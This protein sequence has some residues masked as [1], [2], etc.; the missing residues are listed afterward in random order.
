[1]EKTIN[2][3]DLG[4]KVCDLL[5]EVQADTSVVLER[6]GEPVAAIVP[7]WQYRQ[8]EA[9]RERFF[10]TLQKMAEQA[11]LST[12]EAEAL[13]AEAVAAVRGRK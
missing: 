6:D 9:D 1:M 12:E 2:A 5:D 11:D 13:A 3:E 4:R 7:I 10:S 8:W